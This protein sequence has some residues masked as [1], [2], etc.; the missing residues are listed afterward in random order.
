[1]VARLHR[2]GTV[3]DVR[4]EGE[5]TDIVATIPNRSLDTFAPFLAAASGADVA[6]SAK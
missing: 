3:H 1:L 2:D 4:Y 6:T 5:F